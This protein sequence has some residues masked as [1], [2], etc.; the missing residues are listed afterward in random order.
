M[1]ITTKNNLAVNRIEFGITP[2]TEYEVIHFSY[3][4]VNYF[5]YCTEDK[6]IVL[7]DEDVLSPID[8][9]EK[10]I[11]EHKNKFI[12]VTPSKGETVDILE[13]ENFLIV[14]SHTKG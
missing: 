8:L 13:T 4:G 11:I 10:M 3:N 5:E 12:V 1:K 9:L 14:Y 7:T 6:V 2:N